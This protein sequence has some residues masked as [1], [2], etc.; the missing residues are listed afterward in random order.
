MLHVVPIAEL[1]PVQVCCECR[2]DGVGHGGL[3]AVGHVAGEE[4]DELGQTLGHG[5]RCGQR[6]ATGLHALGAFHGL[7]HLPQPVGHAAARFL[8]GAVQ[9]LL[10]F[11]D[12]FRARTPIIRYDLLHFLQRIAADGAQS[13]CQFE[14]KNVSVALNGVLAIVVELPVLIHY[15]LEHQSFI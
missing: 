1:H 13:H 15:I 14:G 12:A 4:L 6:A 10:P 8:Q 3:V 2:E 5:W 7:Q 11:C 9:R